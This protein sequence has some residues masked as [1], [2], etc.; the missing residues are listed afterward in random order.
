MSSQ[1]Q[2]I[3]RIITQVARMAEELYNDEFELITDA[4]GIE[5]DKHDKD[6]QVM[7]FYEQKAQQA[8]WIW[9]FIT[10]CFIFWCLVKMMF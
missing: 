5:P 3:H 7:W 9:F 4:V 1:I 2:V 8:F 10:A 6:L